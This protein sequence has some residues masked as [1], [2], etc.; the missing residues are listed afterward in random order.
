MNL[1]YVKPQCQP[2]VVEHFRGVG[3]LQPPVVEHFRGV[4]LLQPPVV[5]RFHCGRFPQLLMVANF[6]NG[7]L[8]QTSNHCVHIL[9]AQSLRQFHRRKQK[10][11]PATC[12]TGTAYTNPL[13]TISF[14]RVKGE[15]PYANA[16]VL[17]NLC[18][19]KITQNS[20]TKQKN[21]QQFTRAL[22]KS[23]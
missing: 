11:S 19:A 16:N 18:D 3:L 22:K 13:I 14:K 1:S 8:I 2:P 17:V 23:L 15:L 4:G 7:I 9:S 12:V 10:S 21:L 6:S 20:T 5:E